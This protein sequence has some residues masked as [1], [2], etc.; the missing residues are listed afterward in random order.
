MLGISVGELLVVGVV[1]CL[2]FKPEELP[3]LAG[4]VGKFLAKGRDKLIQ[5][6]NFFLKNHDES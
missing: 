3:S 2:V 4:K 1:A 6:K 5:I